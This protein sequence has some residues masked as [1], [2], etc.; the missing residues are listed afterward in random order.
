MQIRLASLRLA[1]GGQTGETTAHW[2]LV[3][4]HRAARLERGDCELLQQVRQSL[5]QMFA[6]RGVIEDSENCTPHQLPTA[7]P[8]LKLQV[9]MPDSR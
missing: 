8:A 5:L 1:V 3:D 4:L 2:Q 7:E 9:L 6:S